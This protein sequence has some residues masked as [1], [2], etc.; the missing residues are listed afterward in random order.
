MI[1]GIKVSEILWAL[2]LII[3]SLGFAFS[4]SAYFEKGLIFEQS[5]EI[6]S[7]HA[8]TI[9]QLPDG[10]MLCAWYSG[11][12]EGAKDVAE[13]ASRFER[14]TGRWYRPYVLVDTP[15][16]PEGNPVLFVAPDQKVFLYYA[17]ME[18]PGW[19]SSSIKYMVSDD[20]ARNFSPFQFFRKQWGWLPRNHLLTLCSGQI[21]F[22]LYNETLSRSEFMISK[23]QGITWERAGQI[24]SRPG[25]IQP[26]VVEFDDGTLMAL[27]RTTGKDGK[28]WQSY[29]K[30]KGKTWSKAEQTT[31]PNPNA[32]IDLIRLKSGELALAFNNSGQKRT[33]LSIALS[34]DQGKTWPIIKDI[35]TDDAEFSYPSLCQDQ[36][37]KI[38]LTYTWRRK[39]IGY[40][41]FDLQWLEK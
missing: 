22:P 39:A 27:M 6:P 13:W 12:Q 29:S 11:K 10:D 19:T 40:A 2:S 14:K 37:G 31:L 3:F 1:K 24:V 26:A 9:V 33:P 25:N 16:L 4:A 7:S 21:L 15:K 28:I 30:D 8:S 32:G 18:G 38:W 34:Q 23:D 20:N 17:T 35:E 5:P 41:V 36:D